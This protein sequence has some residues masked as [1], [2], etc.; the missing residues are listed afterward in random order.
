VTACLDALEAVF[1]DRQRSGSSIAALLKERHMEFSRA[2][3]AALLRLVSDT[4]TLR[5]PQPTA[6]D[7]RA[8]PG[9]RLFPLAQSMRLNPLK[10]ETRAKPDNSEIG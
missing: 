6:A 4:S 5:R 3:H 7:A 2:P 1:V 8:M 9:K 10:P